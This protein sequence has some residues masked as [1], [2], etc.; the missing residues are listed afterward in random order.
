VGAGQAKDVAAL[1]GGEAEIITDYNNP[2]VERV[3]VIR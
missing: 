3:L 1:F 2:P